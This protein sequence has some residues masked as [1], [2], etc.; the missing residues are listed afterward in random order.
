MSRRRNRRPSPTTD[1]RPP[2]ARLEGLVREPNPERARRMLKRVRDDLDA[3]PEPGPWIAGARTLNE[4]LIIS[5]DTLYYLVELFSECLVY[6]GSRSDSELVR[7]G[8]EMEKIERDHGL[9]EDDYWRIDEAPAEWRSLND[10][11]ERRADEIVD[12]RLRELGHADIADFRRQKPDEF[13]QRTSKGQIDLWGEDE[14]A[15]GDDFR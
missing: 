13:E 11:W 6:E 5:D 12:S 3:A 4:R 15:V 2:E 9:G 1:Q 10:A 14:E 7:I 8:D